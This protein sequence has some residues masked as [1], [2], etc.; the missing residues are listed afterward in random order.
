MKKVGWEALDFVIDGSGREGARREG[1]EGKVGRNEGASAGAV[2]SLLKEERGTC[3]VN[4]TI[5]ARD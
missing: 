3:R 4:V 2:C 1:K 5:G